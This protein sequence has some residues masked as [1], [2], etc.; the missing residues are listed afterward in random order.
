[1]G[2]AGAA[3][4]Y[5]GSYYGLQNAY[6]PGEYRRMDESGRIMPQEPLP[7]APRMRVCQNCGFTREAYADTTNVSPE[8]CGN[9]S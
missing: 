1:M 8:T 3:N 4:A 9:C 6:R 2:L 5:G 7:P